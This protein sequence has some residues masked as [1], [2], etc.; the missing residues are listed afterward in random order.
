MSGGVELGYAD[1]LEEANALKV[2]ME[3]LLICKI[4]ITE[5]WV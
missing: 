3:D 1:S 4:E 5:E 2:K